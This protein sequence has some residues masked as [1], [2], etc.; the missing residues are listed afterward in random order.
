[1]IK[2]SKNTYK[3]IVAS[4]TR[5]VAVILAVVLA[6]FT[7]KAVKLQVFEAEEYKAQALGISKRTAAIKAPRGEIIDCYGRPIATNR[8]GYN[9]VFYSAYIDKE[10]LN[11]TIK[12]LMSILSEN[13]LKWRDD[14]PITVDG[15]LAFTDNSSAVSGLKARLKLA[16]YAT[17]ENCFDELI[18]KYTLQG[19]DKKLQRL[20]AGVRYTM[21]AADFSVSYPYTFAEDITPEVM[22]IISESGFLLK[23]VMVEVAQFREYSADSIAPHVIGKVGPIYAE[24]WSKYKED[25]YTFSDK[26]GISGIE[27]QSEKHLRGKDGE[28][29]Y[30]LNSSG[31]IISQEITKEPVP[32]N[33]I[34]LTIDKTIQKAAQNSLK[35]VINLCNNSGIYVNAGSAVVLNVKTG[36][37]ISA[38]NYPSYTYEQEKNNYASL[39][40]NPNKPL[41]DRAFNGTYPPGSVF[42]PIVALAGL[43]NNIITTS[44]T[45]YC[46]GFYDFYED[47]KPKCMSIHGHVSLNTALAK[48][49]NIY[50]YEVGRRLGI[51]KMNSYAKGFGLG[52]LTGVE[53]ME[54]KGTLAGP[55][56]RD[57]WYEGYTV[58]A[59]I[60]QMDNAFTP[61]QLAT[62]TSTIANS[63]VRY[64][65]TLIDKIFSY[66]QNEVVLE[67]KPIVMNTLKFDDDVLK[68]VKQGMLSVTEDGTGSTVF[69]SYPIKIGGKTGTAQNSKGEDHTVFVAFAPFDNPEIAV[70]VIIEHGQRS[71]YS[72]ELVKSIFD[73]Y[74]FTQISTYTAEPTNTL[75]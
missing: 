51:D 11:D 71:I 43:Q 9:I 6:V 48:S 14:L 54:S 46:R 67:N 75:L 60:G 40:S 20:I 63:G 50:F 31:E 55:D 29:T 17:V 25:G 34:K 44:E 64:K 59:A 39:Q 49:C 41:F 18:D 27:L 2:K 33:T 15:N 8:E 73:T 47:F 35:N 26:V 1:M 4:R 61:I 21:E 13:N 36:G 70:A 24:S 5:V 72:G 19:L 3:K 16:H 7:F 58:Q 52:E 45:I 74:F 57:V 65:T 68:A 66:D 53:V 32:G 30:T 69:K 42:K 37:V 38:A 12:S 28:I 22:S 56:T 62:Y 10:K 23:G